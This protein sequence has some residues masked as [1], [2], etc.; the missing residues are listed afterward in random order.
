[1]TYQIN[2]LGSELSLKLIEELSMDAS[3]QEPGKFGYTLQQ[4]ILRPAS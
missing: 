2:K 3:L 4:Q 1:M